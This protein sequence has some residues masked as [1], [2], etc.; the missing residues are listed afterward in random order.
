[1]C[2]AE[3]VTQRQ[4]E[5][6]MQATCRNKRHSLSTMR[7]MI[8]SIGLV[9]RGNPSTKRRKPR[10]QEETDA[11]EQEEKPRGNCKEEIDA[12]EQ[13]E[14]NQGLAKRKLMPQNRRGKPKQQEEE[15]ESSCD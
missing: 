15:I 10:G 4:V 12:T 11:T 2:K 14:E 7:Y 13:E 3:T 1:M 9:T 6:Q 5:R 8:Q